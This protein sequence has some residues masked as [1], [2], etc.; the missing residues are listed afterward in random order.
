[1]KSTIDG[2]ERRG[3]SN[4]RFGMGLAFIC[5]LAVL[6]NL[7]VTGCT[8]DEPNLVGTALVTDHMDT[9][10]FALGAEDVLTYSALRVENNPDPT[11]KY[12]GI[13]VDKQ[14]VLYLG[15]LGG[16]R[17]GA[18]IANFDFSDSDKFPEDIFNEENIKNVFFSL[19]KLKYHR[20][21][22]DTGNTEPTGQPVNLYYHL[23]ELDGPFDPLDYKNYPVPT[24]PGAG[25][26]LNDDFD[27]P[28]ISSEPL[29]RL[30]DPKDML[31]WI[32]NKEKVGIIVTFG[33]Q[34]DP[35]LVGFASSELTHF[36]QLD[37]LFEGTVAAPNFVVEFQDVTANNFLVEPYDDTS[38]FEKV[39]DAP[40]FVTDGLLM[41][42]GLRSYPALYFDLSALPPNAFINRAVLSVTNDSDVSFGNL[43]G[44]KVLEWDVERFGAPADTINVL[45]LND[46]SARYSFIVTGAT[47]LDP[48]LEETIQFD[49]TQAIL[50]IINNVYL[51]TRGFLLTDEETFYPGLSSTGV[52]PDFYY[53]EFHFKGSADGDQAHRPQ[54][55]IT[56]SV[57]NELNGEGE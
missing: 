10:L 43:G 12:D 52:N 6:V 46:P 7:A 22:A 41:R 25:P 44:I 35:G 34:S 5:A 30:V 17:S 55:K 49:V 20:A 21:Y 54:L 27:E 38:T 50:R 45:D 14:E 48:T 57:V 29:L 1:L 4:K 36:S 24:P 32:A 26:L 31:D 28:I 51:G 3:Q 13:T 42:T 47:S 15:E 18:I 8:S 40:Q 2:T 33:A 37:P 23:Q 11:Q 56:Y 39:T 53:R 16:T 9:V 19:T